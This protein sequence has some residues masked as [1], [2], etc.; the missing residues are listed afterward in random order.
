MAEVK[1]PRKT[2]KQQLPAAVESPSPEV[3][4]PAPMA[5]VGRT[6][7]RYWGGRIDEEFLQ[8]LKWEKALKVYRE[9]AENDATTGALLN[10]VTLLVRQV[11]WRF[12]SEAE[13]DERV[14]FLE[15]CRDDMTHSWTDLN[16][17]I[18]RGTL[19]YG[20]QAHEIVYK[21]RT[22]EESKYPDGKIGWKKLPVRAQDT[23]YRWDFNEA[24]GELLGFV[25]RPAPDYKERYLPMSK[26]LLFRTESFKDNPEGRSILRGAYR[27]WY[28]LKNL[29]N[30]E[31]IGL[32]RRLAGMPVMWVPP[33]ALSPTPSAEDAAIADYAK[34]LVTAI[35]R[36]EDYGVVMPLGYDANGNKLYDLTLLATGGESE[37]D[38][39]GAIQAYQLD[40]LQLMLADFLKLGHEK[41]G[42]FALASNKTNLFAV[43]L[44]VFLDQIASVFN[45]HAIP[46]L[47]AL[48]GM[49]TGD[50][51]QLVHGD[52]EERDM[53]ELA[54]ALQ[55]L[56]TS[57]M[58][59]WPNPRIE[60]KLLEMMG[61]PV[62]TPEEQA[63]RDA[64]R[65]AEEQRQMELQQTMA[66]PPGG[67]GKPPAQEEEKPEPKPAEKRAEPTVVTVEPHVTI[68]QAPSPGV[69][70]T[71]PPAPTP[72]V[73]VEA[74]IT[75]QASAPPIVQVD[76]QPAAPTVQ[77]DVAPSPAPNVTV[78]APDPA[79]VHVTVEA[80]A[81]P[82][83][84]VTTPAPQV[85]VHVPESPAPQ[86]TVEAPV[87]KQG[88]VIVNVEPVADAI[89]EAAEK[90][91]RPD[92]VTIERDAEGRPIRLK[93]EGG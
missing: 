44:G 2:T 16:A 58:P 8:E 73:R 52:I 54:S 18:A 48:N 3:P 88:D 37:V 32:E 62:P 29:Q 53:G 9:M 60:A 83:V 38:T 56:V 92:S 91:K 87:I 11:D 42:S 36:D 66:Q 71:L 89:R 50:A 43:A 61:L 6:G 51:P 35:R 1:A 15:S 68:H 76:V 14:E 25:Q 84:N 93:P 74:P 80:A 21:R 4:S 39:R 49:E 10:A 12:E 77:V 69:S 59:L 40:I 82:V 33:R 55:Q 86:V 5:E 45:R 46:Q 79:Q 63:I 28:F 64:E 65:E 27:A 41:V 7:L 57:G 22:K 24:T 72:E 67:N 31:A 34:K 30:I 23:L 17:E 20:W 75:V 85:D 70:V 78:E 19:T 13:T 26:V 81:P 90:L 47:L